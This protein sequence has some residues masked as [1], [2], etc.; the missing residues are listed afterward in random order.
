MTQSAKIGFILY[1][2][3]FR[4]LVYSAQHYS[5]TQGTHIHI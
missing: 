1:E 4:R 2:Q 3:F 5:S